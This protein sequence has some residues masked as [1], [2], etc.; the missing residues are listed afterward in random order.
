MNTL[1]STF[2]NYFAFWA[3]G[4]GSLAKAASR[5]K[6][7]PSDSLTSPFPLQYLSISLN[8][9]V[10]FEEDSAP[11]KSR[12]TCNETSKASILVDAIKNINNASAWCGGHQWAVVR[13]VLCVDCLNSFCPTRKS[14]V[15]VPS[16]SCLSTR[17]PKM[18]TV[19]LITSQI[20]VA[21]TVPV[22][23]K[24]NL[25]M[26]QN[27]ATVL[28]KLVTSRLSGRVYCSAFSSGV[29]PTSTS[30]LKVSGAS[31]SFT[32]SNGP[33]L[34]TTVKVTGL[35]ALT[36]YDFYCL[37]EDLFGNSGS[38]ASTLSKRV[39]NTTTCCKEVKFSNAPS[40]IYSD[41]TAYTSTS[42]NAYI[43][44]Y[45]LTAAPDLG[46]SLTVTP[47]LFSF[48]QKVSTAVINPIVANF[49]AGSDTTKLSSSF[50]ISGV[51]EGLYTL[52]LSVSGSAAVQFSGLQWSLTV[53]PT[54]ST[55]LPAPTLSYAIFAGSGRSVSIV[56]DSATDQALSFQLSASWSCDTLLSF[57]SAN[58][59]TCSWSNSSA[60]IIFFPFIKTGTALKLL[61]PGD[62]VAIVPGKIRAYCTKVSC[63]YAGYSDSY[64][65]VQSPVNV[66][67]PTA[68]LVAP[69]ILSPCSNLTIDATAST[70]NG[71]RPWKVISWMVIAANESEAPAVS[72]YLNKISFRGI[73]TP[74]EVPLSL[75][76]STSFLFQLKLENFLQASVLKSFIVS[77]SSSSPNNSSRVSYDTISVS[78]AG[79]SFRIIKRSDSLSIQAYLV[80]KGCFSS[81]S[82]AY[83]W[84]IYRNYE[85][86]HA[87]SSNS[88]DP[89]KLLLPAYALNSGETYQMVVTVTSPQGSSA[90][91]IAIVY[92]QMSGIFAA[93]TGGQSREVST[94]DV[95]TLD[96]SSSSDEDT[97]VSI[98]STGL[99]FRWSCQLID[100]A[101]YGQSC[102]LPLSLSTNSSLL[103]VEAGTLVPERTY[104]FQVTVYSSDLQ[105]YS[106]ASTSV[107]AIKELT[108]VVHITSS[109]SIF[110]PND[111]L[112]IT[113]IFSSN[114]SVVS[115]WSGFVGDSSSSIHLPLLS[116]NMTLTSTARTFTT[117]TVLS[118][119]VSVPFP[120]SFSSGVF[121]S[122]RTYTFRLTV[123]PLSP[124]LS[125]SS[126]Y[127]DIQV[128][129]HS[130]PSSGSIT[131]EPISGYG[132]Q[133]E[134]LLSAPQWT[135]EADSYPLHFE[136]L[137]LLD[138]TDAPLSLNSPK[139]L[140]YIGA[141]LPSGLMTNDYIV[142]CIVRV[143]DIYLGLSDASTD[144]VVA[145]QITLDD[146]STL[147]G[148]SLK[149]AFES[150]DVDSIYQLLGGV[151]S[152]ISTSNCS[153]APNCTALGRESCKMT[154]HTCGSCLNGFVGVMGDSNVPCHIQ[155]PGYS[156]TR[157]NCSSCKFGTCINGLC[158]IKSKTCSGA[159]TLGNDVVTCSGHGYC[160][161]V[162]IIDRS[163][164]SECLVT[165]TGCEGQCVCV[166]GY[167]GEDC[168]KTIL[169]LDE[170]KYIRWHLCS[171][172]QNLT[173]IQDASSQLL[174]AEASVL[175]KI[176]DGSELDVDGAIL[177]ATGLEK[178]A[179]YAAAGHLDSA[180]I[181]QQLIMESLSSLVK[182]CNEFQFLSGQ[183]SS[184]ISALIEGVQRGM[185]PGQSASNIMSD[186]VRTSVRY[187]ILT[188]LHGRTLQPPSSEAELAYGVSVPSMTMPHDGLDGC[189]MSSSH[190]V[191]FTLTQWTAN[192]HG[193]STDLKSSLIRYSSSTTNSSLTASASNS[194]RHNTSFEVNLMFTTAQNW[195][196]KVP[197][198]QLLTNNKNAPCN[199]RA[200]RYSPYNVT[201]L[202]WDMSVLCPIIPTNSNTSGMSHSARNRYRRLDFDFQGSETSSSSYTDTTKSED[203]GAFVI[204]LGKEIPATLT[205]FPNFQQALPAFLLVGGLVFVFAV[206]YYFLWKWD[207][208]D[209]QLIIF[210]AT[211]RRNREERRRIEKMHQQKLQSRKGS[212]ASRFSAMSLG[213]ISSRNSEQTTVSA[214]N[215]TQGRFDLKKNFANMG[216]AD[217]ASRRALNDTSSVAIG[218]RISEDS[219]RNMFTKYDSSTGPMDASAAE[220]EDSEPAVVDPYDDFEDLAM[221]AGRGGRIEE[222][223]AE[224]ENG[225]DG[226]KKEGGT[227][228]APRPPLRPIINQQR[229]TSKRMNSL[230]MDSGSFRNLLPE[231]IADS[232]T[233]RL[234]KTRGIV[235]RYLKVLLRDHD[236]IRIFTYKSRRMTRTIRF[237]IVCSDLLAL[238]FMDSLFY[239]VLFPSNASTCADYSAENG[240]TSNECLSQRS[241]WQGRDLCVWNDDDQTCDANPPPANFE[242]FVVVTM[243]VSVFSIPFQVVMRYILT[244]VISKD[245]D[246]RKIA[247]MI[248]SCFGLFDFI[249][250]LLHPDESDRVSSVY[251]K[252]Q[253]TK[254]N[255][256]AHKA[257]IANR[258]SLVKSDHA[259]VSTAPDSVWRD[260]I[261]MKYSFSDL[262]SV[263]EEVEVLLNR[264]R[265]A[266]AQELETV[267]LPWD[268][269]AN[270]SA[271]EHKGRMDAIM[272]HLH[273][274]AD[275]TPVPL[276]W[277]QWLRHGSAVRRI[278]W[279]L[280]LIRKREW[281]VLESVRDAVTN[282]D[283]DAALVKH[284]ILEQLPPFER[285]AVSN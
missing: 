130:P 213:T 121:S 6:S 58:I 110:N 233:Q 246:F 90:Q 69:S 12:L 143:T 171:A 109:F 244:E 62:R 284:F 84:T 68:V 127:A 106:Q 203:M 39:T 176:I 53:L 33:D 216:L 79:S 170:L 268:L 47:I 2:N 159:W 108:P 239:G 194:I 11:Y 131:V 277:W 140:P 181:A 201:F 236:W 173:S 198:C 172:L 257:N 241:L 28:V 149:S 13:G 21:S 253:V 60:I 87:L 41:L 234:L 202:C 111:K 91:A 187:D 54:P 26:G 137:C 227:N 211:R 83:S 46:T 71:G 88:S 180:D 52:N 20:K 75:L 245:T 112:T 50:V 231:F 188:D 153:L 179:L 73:S 242:F 265:D 182:I 34:T 107:Y 150:L 155:L 63:T 48:G 196:H 148:S 274:Y 226:E 95:L 267:P 144:V 3:N 74:L 43:F 156:P 191:Q 193:N 264:V 35:L 115:S 164:L 105:R 238:L 162:N 72:M 250:S 280:G 10:V 163:I 165:D 248:C 118:S 129:A 18:W 184:I 56:F 255:P 261:K 14:S 237:L 117:S 15:V 225:E 136:F 94:A 70:G 279:K 223:E 212:L 1:S 210:S 158:Q 8:S 113:A 96:A 76:N 99:V 230:R 40:F 197:G 122:G 260:D 132:L 37:T 82:F 273:L 154:S 146:V 254:Y 178:L 138:V 272:A 174:L 24:I 59:S 104:K 134:F 204:A 25:L 125:T 102:G 92:V 19:L 285:Y 30:A 235:R 208:L 169:Q 142:L 64:V 5:W 128:T 228:K 32:A 133:T 209:R 126:S 166:N 44:K 205:R 4:A 120:L 93:I 217:F 141:Q 85:L 256:L 27:S 278:E 249:S 160:K 7:F 221:Y 78:I 240:G 271:S 215:A 214:S 80:S 269:E 220:A 283:K 145:S 199:C 65:S 42:P 89:R 55:P 57:T 135:A 177:C 86:V 224:D 114:I 243:L 259:S 189:G 77:M 116:G 161:Y 229:R 38:L 66:I 232:L 168:S 219:T 275:G 282:E 258:A 123:A 103:A 45:Y 206:A 270:L 67:V 186:Y 192:P 262:L 81:T 152:F 31:A 276:T 252:V 266:L 100:P 22:I 195:T 167:G 9:S 247:V 207:V 23:A 51:S 200:L 36:T 251:K 29:S 183:I 49:V 61:E 97:L 124:S 157:S 190:Y 222:A 101:H 139:E 151:S 175:Q 147:L 16:L 281:L 263:K 185:T 17:G 218:R 119:F 98:P